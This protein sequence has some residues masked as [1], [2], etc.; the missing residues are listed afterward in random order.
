MQDPK[1][2]EFSESQLKKLLTLVMRD[3][4]DLDAH[5]NK[6]M[7]SRE[8]SY[9]FSEKIIEYQAE[10]ADLEC[11]EVQIAWSV[12]KAIENRKVTSN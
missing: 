11:M 10:V 1:L 12:L 4:I 9:M 5:V 2:S 8:L 3:R 7:Q 6:L